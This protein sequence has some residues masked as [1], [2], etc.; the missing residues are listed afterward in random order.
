MTDGRKTDK[1]ELYGHR[2]G[3]FVKGLPPLFVF[4]SEGN[5]KG[6]RSEKV[7]QLADEGMPA[8]IYNAKEWQEIIKA[9]PEM[10]E[11]TPSEHDKVPNLLRYMKCG[12]KLEE[13]DPGCREHKY[14]NKEICPDRRFMTSWHPGWHVHRL[15][16]MIMGLYLVEMAYEAASRL[17]A[18]LVHGQKD[19]IP[20]LK[21]ENMESPRNF[22]NFFNPKKI[23]RARA[24]FNL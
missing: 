17:D 1:F 21:E 5:R 14:S 20:G 24:L 16:G 12:G 10:T 4:G 11:I 15:T 18:I 2:A 3:M 13:G 23:K 6:G 19:T 22:S 7:K 9:L 8:L